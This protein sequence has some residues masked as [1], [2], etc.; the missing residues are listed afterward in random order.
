MPSLSNLGFACCPLAWFPSRCFLHILNSFKEEEH[1]KTF[2][3]AAK[4]KV[5]SL[6][7]SGL[8]SFDYEQR[9]CR[10]LLLVLLRYSKFKYLHSSSGWTHTNARSDFLKILIL[11]ILA[12]YSLEIQLFIPVLGSSQLLRPPANLEDT[13]SVLYFG[14][15]RAKAWEKYTGQTSAIPILLE[16]AGGVWHR[17]T[18]QSRDF[19]QWC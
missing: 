5:P 14:K 10:L 19:H 2:G 11:L 12:P 4:K 8:M 13:V 7:C 15:G 3:N 17:W 6:S 9:L 16:I 1:S 18:L